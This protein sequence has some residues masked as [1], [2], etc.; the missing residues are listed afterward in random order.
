MRP[1][2]RCARQRG[3][4]DADG[5]LV[6]V[7]LSGTVGADVGTLA[8]ASSGTVPQPIAAARLIAEPA[9]TIAD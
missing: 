2:V 8:V 6:P 4:A 3:H 7:V 9:A 1:D 5:H